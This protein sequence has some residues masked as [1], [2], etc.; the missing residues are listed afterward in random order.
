M[1][2]QSG[3]APKPALTKRDLVAKART[4]LENDVASDDELNAL[5]KAL[6]KHDIFEYAAELLQKRIDR[7][8]GAAALKD[9]QDL[10]GYIYKD[11]SL[12]AD[13]RFDKAFRVLSRIDHPASSQNCETLGLS[14]AIFKRYWQAKHQDKHL[15]LS[16]RFYRKGYSL[17]RQYL[18]G[19]GKDWN[20]DNRKINAADNGY[21][22]INY[23]YI[24]ELSATNGLEE[25]IKIAGAAEV[26][27]AGL[28][29]AQEVRAYI[30]SQVIEAPFESPALKIAVASPWIVATIAEAY[31]GLYRYS[32]ALIFI[33]DYKA[34]V[35]SDPW[36]LRSFGSQIQSL[37]YLQ[38]TRQRLLPDRSL[39]G[40]TREETYDVDKMRE[41]LS[42][43]DIPA[44]PDQAVQERGKTGL[45]L[46]GGG[47]RASLYHIGVLAALA[48]GNALKDIEVISCVSGGSI[49][50]AFYYLKLKLLLEEKTD[51]EIVP[52]DYIRLV[53]EIEVEFLEGVKK[54]LRMRVFSN[55]PANIRMLWKDYSRTNRLGELYDEFLYTPLLK[56]H[57][58]RLDALQKKQPL[59]KRETAISDYKKI[60]A[61]NGGFICMKN[62]L[63]CID[64]KFSPD[65]DNWKRNNKVPRLILNATS[66][67]T[68]HNWQFT[69]SWM[70]EPASDIISDID[71]KPRLRRFYYDDAPEEKYRKFRLGYAVGASSC[72]PVM[73]EPLPMSGVYPDLELQLI[74]GGLHDNQGIASII[75]EEC[76]NVYVSDASGQLASS[77]KQV[78][79]AV[80]LFMRADNIL[81]ERLRE[82][83]FQD[84]SERKATALVDVLQKLHLKKGLQVPAINW[85]GCGDPARKIS[86]AHEEAVKQE[87]KPPIVP[88]SMQQ[89]ISE[90]RTDLDAFHDTE[91]FALMHNGYMQ[92]RGCLPQLVDIAPASWKFNAIAPR[93]TNNVTDN[94]IEKKL[95]VSARVPFKVFFLAP[96][97]GKVL[98]VLPVL[99]LIVGLIWYF[100]HFIRHGSFAVW[101]I[102]TGLVIMLIAKLWPP[103]S[104]VLNPRSYVLKILR[105]IAILFA[106]WI[107]SGLYL[108]LLNRYYLS[109]G[110]LSNSNKP[111]RADSGLKDAANR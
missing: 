110:N 28:Q 104:I 70:G 40:D 97:Y 29:E 62:L 96:W 34:M 102:A 103:A 36:E 101:P 95:A 60:L 1:N 94:E 46:S 105:L 50:G 23:A 9:Y 75:E 83:Q 85:I 57:I 79:G 26:S 56:K 5:A 58:A 24:L 89:R 84:M 55:L 61:D 74:D 98:I 31:F 93:I 42:A 3:G 100:W 51:H 108:G 109:L 14:G 77:N 19:E 63:I 22:A 71:V 6:V 7:N 82:L 88:R 39:A 69:A 99:L 64:D 44:G 35:N 45:A 48:E 47:F 8:P 92:M 38:Q 41:C 49:I 87:A 20:D 59:P 4:Y 68:G 15:A 72:V 67:N 30:L 16:L 111:A 18:S 91:A 25:V 107:V 11:D 65:K 90:I 106:G 13:F 53:K 43:L 66:V 33:N 81:Q 10:S 12:P 76:R 27:L 2:S 78:S 86:Y 32:D 52:D 17:W 73:F 21:N 54:N 80:A 37:A